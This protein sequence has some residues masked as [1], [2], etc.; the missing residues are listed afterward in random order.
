MAEKASGQCGWSGCGRA[1]QAYFTGRSFCL[2]HFLELTHR[3]MQSIVQIIESDSQE[4]NVSPEA[5]NFLSEV[6]SET[7]VLAAQTKLLAPNQRDE[8]ISLSTKAAEL[9]RRIHRAPRFP[10]HV[11]CLLRAGVL[12]TEI[13]EKCYTVNISVR[14][15]CLE[16]RSLGKVGR[17]I[18]LERADTKRS[19]RAK[20]AWAK[21]NT[22]G[23]FLVGLEILDHEDFWGLGVSAAKY[24]SDECGAKR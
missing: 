12:S 8:L 13:S 9:Y 2:D 6:I 11:A 21:E 17:T 16:V 1:A 24:A 10:R 3:R 15:A 7:T 4:R 22:A 19:A 5:Q 14:G 18:L 20:I 23:R